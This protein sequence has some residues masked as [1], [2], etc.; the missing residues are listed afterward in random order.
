M[1]DSFVAPEA[2]A[3][4]TAV[5]THSQRPVGGVVKLECRSPHRSRPSRHRWGGPQYRT[6]VDAAGTGWSFH[7]DEPVEAESVVGG[8]AVGLVVGLVRAV[9]GDVEG[10]AFLVAAPGC[11][12]E[13]RVNSS[14]LARLAPWV[15]RCRYD[16]TAAC[17]RVWKSTMNSGTSRPSQPRTI[18]TGPPSRWAVRARALRSD[19]H[20]EGLFAPVA[21]G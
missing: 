19:H 13:Q 4:P 9:R 2:T 21:E 10:G 18:M 12:L 5:R 3:P 1:K 14:V 20:L 11:H 7:G 15:I 17:I 6:E 8:D 16:T